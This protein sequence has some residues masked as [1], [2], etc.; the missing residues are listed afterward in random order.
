MLS[1]PEFTAQ[2]VASLGVERLRKAEGIGEKGLKNIIAWLHSCGFD[3][4]RAV[5]SP[6]NSKLT[7]LKRAQELLESNGYIV[8]PLPACHLDRDKAE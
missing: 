8:Q 6:K 7:R 2:Q 4:D 1:R 5:S 3:I